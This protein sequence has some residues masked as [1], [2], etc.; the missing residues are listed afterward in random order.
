M[1][2]ERHLAHRQRRD[3]RRTV[4]PFVISG[5]SGPVTGQGADLAEQGQD[6]LGSRVG[7]GEDRRAGLLEDLGLGEGDHLGGNV[8]VPDT[9]H[10]GVEVLRG[11]AD[12]GRGVLQA[13]L[14]RTEIATGLGDVADGG[15]DARDQG[16]G[17]SHDAG[18]AGGRGGSGEGR[19]GG[20]EVAVSGCARARA[21]S[22]ALAKVTLIESAAL[23]PTWKLAA[24][25]VPVATVLLAAPGAEAL[26][27]IVLL[28]AA[29]A[30]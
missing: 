14:D 6:V 26:T 24:A 7:L 20:V 18:S 3:R 27:T 22:R 28:A 10:R 15:V 4:G 13:V 11:D 21:L 16:L 2:L 8:E 9:G 5:L 12:R 17:R 23:A 19:D 1:R 30:R 29:S 25:P